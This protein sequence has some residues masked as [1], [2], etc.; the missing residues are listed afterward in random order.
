MAAAKTV[1]ATRTADGIEVDTGVIRARIPTAGSVLVA[2]VTRGDREIFR[3]G[4]LVALCDDRPS[5][6]AEE[7]VRTASFESEISTVTLEQEGPLRAVVKI[8]GKH[9]G[10]GRSWL[11]FTVRLYFHAGG[12][13][14]RVMHSFVFDGDEHKDFLRGLGL[15]FDV[16]MGDELHDRH[17]RFAGEGRGVWA[18]AVRGLTGLRRE[19][20]PAVR[21][22]QVQ[23]RACPPLSEFPENIRSRLQYVPAWGD[24]T[25]AQLSANAFAIRKRT[26]QG[27]GWIDADQGRRSAG[28]GYVGGATAGGVVFGLRDFWQ[29]HPTQLDIRAANT[30]QAQVTLWMW[31]PEAP[32]MDLRFYH[33]GMGMDTHE[34]QYRGGL[35]ITYEDY[36][37]GWGTAHGIARS[38]EIMLWVL[39]GTP[40]RERLVE[41]AEAVRTPAMLAAVPEHILGTKVFGGLWSLPDRSTPAKASIEGRLDWQIDFY[42]KQVDQRHW[43]G[44]WNYGDVMHTYDADRHVWRYDVGGFAWDNSELSPDLWLWYTYLRSGRPDV[45]RLA[46]AM[47]RHTGEVDVYHAGRFKGLGTRHNVQHWGCSA[48]QVRISTA[49]YR[50]IYYYLTGDERVGDLMRELLDADQLLAA[51]DPVRKI[52]SER[53][54]TSPHST[55]VNFGTDWTN[56]AA[57]WLAE[58]ERGGDAKYRDKLLTGMKDI[59][60]AK[61]GFFSGNRFGYDPA[62]G[63]LFD[64][65][66]EEISISHLSAVFGAVEIC[67]ELIQLT[68]GDP[69]YL[70]F[71]KAW[72]QY[73]ELYNASGEERRRVLGKDFRSGSLTQAHSRLTAYV[74][75]RRKDRGLAERAWKEFMSRSRSLDM[76]STRLEGPDV[77]NP[78]DESLSVSTNDAS[79]WGLAAIQN[80]ALI[81]DALPQM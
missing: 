36:E 14:L 58:W 20:G 75:A 81:G 48:K 16:A 6:G 21:Q 37:P 52:E 72:E 17:V 4:R 3:N 76:Q 34:E 13:S 22:A 33:D 71:A 45:F 61:Y 27:H 73:C 12:E 44:F 26:K 69:A 46:E 23:G 56:I 68:E 24:Y 18:E 19:V 57:G 35:D 67:A 11:P 40:T 28:A 55:H 43:Y 31:S 62:T 65:V 70:P 8:E 54:A 50:R 25:L 53:Q 77:L 5:E 15:R 63:R 32:A 30:E 38:S 59:G 79:Q 60:A 74:A 66:G 1:R 9:A 49:A 51:V 78:V 10:A 80:L 2:V 42:R 47:T 41:F 7:T 64:V 39:P 29:R